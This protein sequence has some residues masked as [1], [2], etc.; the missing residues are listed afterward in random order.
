VTTYEILKRD[1]EKLKQER[2]YWEH[3]ANSL[4]RQWLGVVGMMERV[5]A[6]HPCNVERCSCREIRARI[7]A[8]L[9]DEKKT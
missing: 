8:K 9:T 2:D 5:V 6:A 3:R 4:R 1:Y 7:D